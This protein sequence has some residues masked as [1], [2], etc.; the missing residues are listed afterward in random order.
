MTAACQHGI[1]HG[2]TVNWEDGS[3]NQKLRD[4]GTV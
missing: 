3:V 2:I 4:R 1:T